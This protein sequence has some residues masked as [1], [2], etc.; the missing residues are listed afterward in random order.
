M[1]VEEEKQRRKR[2]EMK[3]RKGPVKPGSRPMWGYKNTDL[4]KPKKQS[5]KDPFYERK[6]RESDMRRV[7]REQKLLAMV[8]A[9]K[10]IIPDYYV[11]PPRS[12]SHSR[13]PSPFSDVE[14]ASP[15]EVKLG[16]RSKSHSPHRH[17]LHG[18][19]D[20]FSSNTS[21][22]SKSRPRETSR[23]PAR[24]ESLLGEQNSSVVPS[25]SR[26]RSPPVPALRHKSDQNQN[27]NNNPGLRRGG[28][29]GDVD[30]L[31]IPVQNGEFVPFTR[32]IEVLDPTKA[33]D[34]LPLSREA[35]KVANARR[36]YYEGLHPEKFGNKQYVYVDKHRVLPGP[37][38]GSS[39]VR[40]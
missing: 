14:M 11:P 21:N 38:D 35:T 31:D 28:R 37:N 5:E 40:F 3:R 4:V 22:I 30:P 13:D 2:L 26:N 39:K 29:Y 1:K 27:V 36:A 19:Y 24:T 33:E 7:K 16:R 12:R 9:N 25:H 8:N 18:E 10:E 34:P 32:T 17:M 23:S 20:N 15:R 6:K